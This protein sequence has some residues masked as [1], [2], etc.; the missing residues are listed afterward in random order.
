MKPYIRLT[1]PPHGG[2]TPSP[3]ACLH[4]LP[5]ICERPPTVNTFIRQSFLI[6]L[7]LLTLT[8]PA[9]CAEKPVLV[10]DPDGHK[11]LIRDIAFT[12][13][14]RYLLSAGDDK[15]VRVWD[16][17]S[18]KTVRFIRGQIGPGNEG[19]IFA[20]ALSPDGRT[21]AVGGWMGPIA[22]YSLEEVGRIRL[23]DVATGRVLGILKGHDS[24]IFSLSFSPDSNFLASGQASGQ[25]GTSDP[26]VR[27]WDVKQKQPLHVLKGHKKSIY[28]LA[29]SLDGQRVVSGSDDHT[30]I[31]WDVKTGKRM[32][33]LM[34]HT[35]DVVSAT[36]D[37]TG[38]YIASGSYDHTIRLWD[39]TTGRFIKTLADQG[40]QV[41]S[42]SFSPD[43]KKLIS[44]VV[45]GPN[46]H[47]HVWSVPDGKELVTFREHDNIVLATAVSPDGRLVATGGGNNQEILIW[48]ME[49]G[50]LH[51]RLSGQGASV[52]AVG[53]SRDGRRMT[54]GQASRQDNPLIR[55]PLKQSLDLKT[56]T[57]N[58]VPE[59]STDYL[60]A[61]DTHGPYGLTHKKGGD[62]GYDAILELSKNSTVLARVER[63]TTDGS[64]HWCYTFTPDG[65]FVVSGGANGVL[66]L[67]TL[68]DLEQKTSFIGHEGVVWAVA[69][70]P[71][72]AYLVSGAH[73]QTVRL[74]DLNLAQNGGT[75]LPLIT[76]FPT[77]DG[78]EWLAWTP[79]GYYAGSDRAGRFVGYQLN[80]GID[81]TPK[82]ISSE[83]LEQV[84]YRPDLVMADIAGKKPTG[85]P[86][87]ETY[88]AQTRAPVVQIISPAHESTVDGDRISLRYT[89]KNEGSGIGKV[90]IYLNGTAVE[91]GTRTIRRKETSSTRKLNL[92]IE[93][94]RDNLI[95][96]V[97][98]DA[99][100]ELKS[101][102]VSVHVH[103][104]ANIRKPDF[105]ALVAG[106]N[107][108]SNPDISLRFARSDAEAVAAVLDNKASSK[109]FR[110][111]H[112]TLLTDE[113]ATVGNIRKALNHLKQKARPE[114]VVVIYLASHGEIR[115]GRY[116]LLT[117]S[118][119]YLMTEDLEKSCLLEEELRDQLSEIPASKKLLLID[120]CK[121]GKMVLAMNRGLSESSTMELLSRAV[122]TYVISAATEAQYASEGYN[123]HGLF[124]Y[125]LIKGLE[126]AADLDGNGVV[127]VDELK[128]YVK[129]RVPKLSQKRFGRRQLPVATGTG[130]SFPL[131][132]GE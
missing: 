19:K 98:W 54:W 51:Q 21:V 25:Y 47:C 73:D 96:I 1:L 64:G 12:P 15:A 44:G 78:R 8:L 88:L 108:F 101:R 102:E 69:C 48:D 122:G 89:I 16:T 55:G 61:T 66:T 23:H 77:K 30:L 94:G 40:T 59:N 81:K 37:P 109:L 4:S 116:F 53:F 130:E 110:N 14:G 49:S 75:I 13:D 114:D 29:F 22:G 57:L 50:T 84:F 105:W 26:T 31:L 6:L 2:F 17:T 119:D 34:G 11:A 33:T 5:S 10:L 92:A 79:E 70:S 83:Q 80:R 82:F 3:K 117:T 68:P 123:G 125:V 112:I 58:N 36:Y 42:L 85:F 18:G 65:R 93:A 111:T 128:L 104:K 132:M 124:S 39:G 28:G 56:L 76:L 67:Y 107:Q 118:T 27:I 62:Y 106:I 71:D 126:G 120:A 100:N 113:K 86:D 60:R 99:K 46:Y 20:M 131:V 45:Q 38:R 35:D 91:T 90:R 103:S 24:A 87:I 52:W 41:G 129:D 43:G 72:G 32:A 9:L 115:E 121:S 74:W 97:A 63:G 7:L 127:E 95:S